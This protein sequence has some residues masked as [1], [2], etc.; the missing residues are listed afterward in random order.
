[1]L[2]G[3]CA[4][5]AQC[6][7]FDVTLVRV[8]TV[9]LTVATG[10]TGLVLYVTGWIVMPRADAAPAPRPLGDTPERLSADMREVGDRLAEAARGLADKAREAAEEI[11]EIARRA[12]TAPTPP[13]APTTTAP[14]SSAP[15]VP[16]EPPS[17]AIDPDST[18]A[19]RVGET[20]PVTPPP[21]V[22]P[23]PPPPTPPTP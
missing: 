18:V 13:E 21:A 20:P 7:D 11:S 22:Q 3:V 5:V 19:P 16:P 12:R 2:G 1:M 17:D 15:P 8:V 6:Y 23:P 14:E 10:G 9:L 4:G